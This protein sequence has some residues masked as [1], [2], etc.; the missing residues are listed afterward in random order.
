MG[1]LPTMSLNRPRAGLTVNFTP[2]EKRLLRGIK[3]ADPDF[4]SQT[5]VV[6]WLVREYAA[7][8]LVEKETTADA[9]KK[10]ESHRA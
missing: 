3:N 2:D 7:G 9:P 10:K 4:N 8:R 5:D 1:D 6:R